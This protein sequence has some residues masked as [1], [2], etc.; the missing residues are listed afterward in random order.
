MNIRE[1]IAVQMK[2]WRR[3][4]TTPLV[5][6]YGPSANTPGA[7]TS[8]SSRKKL[9]ALSEMQNDTLPV[10]TADFGTPFLP[11]LG[12]ADY[13]WNGHSWWAVPS[14]TCAADLHINPFDEQHPLWQKY[15][16]EFKKILAGWSWDTYLPGPA[17]LVGPMDVLSA[18]LGPETLAMEL[19]AAPDEV[20]RAA[21]EAVTLFNGV[22]KAQLDMIRAAGLTEGIADWMRIWMPGDGICYSE[23]FAALCGESHFREF[24]IEPNSHIMPRLDTA[25]LHLHSGALACLPAVLEIPGLKALELSNDPSGP[26]LPQ[27]IA[28]AQKV[29]AAGI[30]L[31]LSNWERP[32]PRRDIEA[33][34]DSLAPQGLKITLQGRSEEEAW[35]LFDLVKKR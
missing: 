6:V 10:Q 18:S 30:P 3:E 34:L 33:M 13:E 4:N 14:A 22:L 23:D 8:T 2:W 31:Q 26:A 9:P 15:L 12:G 35:E 19:Y 27:L 17:V 28:G 11:A 5:Q 20:H 24:F 32:L 7:Q 29:Q 25:F 1:I 16:V 21:M